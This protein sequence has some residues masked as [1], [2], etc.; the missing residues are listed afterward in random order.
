MQ[1]LCA[2]TATHDQVDPIVPPHDV[3]VGERIKFEGFD[4]EPDAQLNPRKKIF[5]TIAPDL[6]TSAGLSFF[7]ALFPASISLYLF[8]WINRPASMLSLNVM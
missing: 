3:P 7:T 8:P 4:G 5:E 1:V 2:S 6:L